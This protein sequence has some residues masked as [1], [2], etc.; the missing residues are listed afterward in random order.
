MALAATA[1]VAAPLVWYGF[2]PVDRQNTSLANGGTAAIGMTAPEARRT[3]QYWMLSVMALAMALGIAGIVVHLPPLFQDLGDDP[4]AAA[5]TA[6]LVGLSSVFGRIA[7][8]MMLDRF[9][10]SLVSMAILALAMLGIVLLWASGLHYAPLA[11]ILLG[12]AAGAEID[13]LAYLTARFFGQRAYGAI[14]GWQYSK[15]G[16][17]HV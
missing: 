3:R 9:V 5:R 15:I 16:R 7:V 17:A 10:P 8:G 4:L 14:Y 1:F 2:R 12:L 6:S 11:V 13:L